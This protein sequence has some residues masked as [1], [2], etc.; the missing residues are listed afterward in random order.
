VHLDTD[1]GGDPD[2]ACA[3]ALL[4]GSSDAELVGITTN[5]EVDGQR[6]G[7]AAH[8]L[9]L[10]DRTDVPV[11]AGAG[12]SLTTMRTYAPTFGDTRY[13]ADP[14]AP[15]PSAPG[16][17]LDAL[18][19]SIEHG[20]TVIAIGAFTNLALLEVGRPGTLRDV[21][22]VAM[23]GWL[24]DQATAGFPAWGAAMDWNVQCDARAAAIVFDAAPALTLVT[25]P[26]A[27]HAQLRAS[28]LPT[29]RAAAPI[30]NLLATQSEQHALDNDFAA[31]ASAHE[32][33]ADD[34]VNFHWDPVT[35]AV[36]LGWPVATTETMTLVGEL[37]DEHFEFRPSPNGRPTRVVTAVDADAFDEQ[38]LNAIRATCR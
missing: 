8:Y 1:F 34:L 5:L 4:L 15:L 7:C 31:L 30:G 26:A 25:L 11:V 22:I 10:A 13:W 2:D 18:H 3:L 21:P 27:M 6:A 23:A 19:A 9:R 33:L 16:A 32:R 20:A 29:L 28:Q 36:A 38:W 17:A 35:A 24:P 12:A 37:R 14:V